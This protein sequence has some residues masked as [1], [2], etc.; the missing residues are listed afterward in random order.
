MT[1]CTETRPNSISNSKFWTQQPFKVGESQYKVLDQD[2]ITWEWGR[3][4]EAKVGLSCLI[5]PSINIR[6]TDQSSNRKRGA[7]KADDSCHIRFS[8]ETEVSYEVKSTLK[9]WKHAVIIR[10]GSSDLVFLREQVRP[11][12][13]FLFKSGRSLVF[14]RFLFCSVS[15]GEILL[16]VSVWGFR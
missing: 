14:S 16:R 11:V 3:K 10:R 13:L 4:P 9:V 15:V 7:K 12:F 6:S 2:G 1:R 5:V 8:L